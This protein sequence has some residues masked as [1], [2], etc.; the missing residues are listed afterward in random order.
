MNLEIIKNQKA[1]LPETYQHAKQSL[2]T[3]ERID[4]CKDWADKASALASYAKQAD[5]GELENFAK[6]IRIRAL[7]R[8]GELL[9]AIEAK[10]GQ[11]TDLG[12][13]ATTGKK[14]AARVA[15][16]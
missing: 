4:E 3:C 2:A 14:K 15:G 5:D 9:K 8:C 11:R 16:H 12:T 1:K 10:P 6:R 7:R 13:V